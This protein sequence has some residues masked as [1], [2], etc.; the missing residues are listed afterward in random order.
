[1]AEPLTARAFHHSE[2]VTDWRACDGGASAWFGASSFRGGAD[3][4]QAV[5]ELSECADHPPDLDI[6][7]HGVM[8]RLDTFGP[9][10]DGLSTL[11]VTAARA[12]SAVARAHGLIPDPSRIG[13]MVLNIGSTAPARILPFWG[14]VLA[15]HE[16]DGELNDPLRRQP[17]VCFQHLETDRPGHGR[18]HVDV[19]VPHDRAADRVS[20]A[21]A[22]G[23][24]LVTDQMA[25]S[26]WVL[27][28]SDGNE[29]C[30]ATWIGTDGRGL[31]RLIYPADGAR[32]DERPDRA[33]GASLLAEGRGF[34]PLGAHVLDS[35]AR[36][37]SKASVKRACEDS[38]IPLRVA[39]SRHG[40]VASRTPPM[41]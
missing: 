14:A 34:E 30:V 36:L 23:G 38:G 18:V 10:P 8:V 12:I 21:L 9:T 25:P 6:R 37:A 2:G 20:A 17:V 31:S 27:A 29:A 7:H 39:T 13:N 22:A 24:H 11:D 1:M 35:S 26:W 3:F 41:I 32:I 16:V 28:D 5:A 19:W 33:V 15:L 40:A 4:G